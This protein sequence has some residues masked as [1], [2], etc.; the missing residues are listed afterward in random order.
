MTG[1]KSMSLL[2]FHYWDNIYTTI[3]PKNPQARFLVVGTGRYED[4]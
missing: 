3:T 4:E 1:E 2:I